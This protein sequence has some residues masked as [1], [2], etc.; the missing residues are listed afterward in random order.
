MLFGL[1]KNGTYEWAYYK[2]PAMLQTDRNSTVAKMVCKIVFIHFFL[3]R[4]GFVP[5]LA[6]DLKAAGPA[7]CFGVS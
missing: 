3:V 2:E 7:I 6:L 4:V 5:V 1:L